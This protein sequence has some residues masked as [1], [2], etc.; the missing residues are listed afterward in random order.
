MEV[1]NQGVRMHPTC[2]LLQKPN[3]AL[4]SAS[5]THLVRT[6]LTCIF[7]VCKQ[8][9]LEEKILVEVSKRV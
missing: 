3:I 8:T 1:V 9:N 2:L 6:A 4:P 7:T 5:N